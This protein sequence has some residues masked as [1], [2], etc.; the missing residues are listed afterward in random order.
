MITHDLG[1]VAELCDKVAV[2]YAGKIVEE[3][4]VEDI[5]DR[6]KHPYTIGLLI[7]FPVLVNRERLQ[8]IEGQPPNMHELPEGCRFA[9][10]CP[11]VMDQC[12]EKQPEL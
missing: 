4:T 7:P 10:R 9:D 3:G 5:F 12:L 11:F 8:P 1:V 6:P 2:M